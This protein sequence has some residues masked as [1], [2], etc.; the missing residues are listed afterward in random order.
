MIKI[1]NLCLLRGLNL[2]V[3]ESLLSEEEL[4]SL[5]YEYAGKPRTERRIILPSRTCLR[6]CLVYYITEKHEGDFSAVLDALRGEEGVLAWKRPAKAVPIVTNPEEATIVLKY[7]L[8]QMRKTAFIQ[9]YLPDKAEELSEV[10][11]LENSISN[12]YLS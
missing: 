9:K 10:L 4:E 2:A 6:K 3:L 7:E 1:K 5:V 8:E 11:G 12:H